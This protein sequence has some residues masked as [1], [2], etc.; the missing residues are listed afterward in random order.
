MDT[1]S[2]A[3]E[4]PEIEQSDG[5]LTDGQLTEIEKTP[6]LVKRKLY[7]RSQTEDLKNFEE[8]KALFSGMENTKSPPGGAIRITDVSKPT[9]IP[10]MGV[11]KQKDGSAQSKSPIFSNNLEKTADLIDQSKVKNK[12]ESDT[13][14]TNQSEVFVSKRTERVPVLRRAS[15]RISRLWVLYVNLLSI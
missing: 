2:S 1:S 10:R 15:R 8:A 9:A 7:Q 12:N 5:R 14:I 3:D 6:Q 13:A 11:M 4:S